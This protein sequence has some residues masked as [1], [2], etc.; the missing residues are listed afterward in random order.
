VERAEGKKRSEHL[1]RSQAGKA[2]SLSVILI[3]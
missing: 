2:G 3:E 1:T